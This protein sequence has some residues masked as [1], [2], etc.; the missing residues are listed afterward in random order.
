VVLAAV[1]SKALALLIAA[2]CSITSVRASACWDTPTQVAARV[3]EFHVRVSIA[4]LRCHAINRPID[5]PLIGYYARYRQQIEAAEAHLKGK[6]VDDSGG[7]RAALNQYMS[8]LGN[9]YGA[10]K[11]SA[12]FCESLRDMLTELAKPES[13]ED[14][15][16]TYALLLVREPLIYGLC[17]KLAPAGS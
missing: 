6:L 11:S 15:L 12:S 13:T 3:Y 8:G 9:R 5:A 1:P 16:H 2:A 7:G 10:D 14:D 17:A 4:E